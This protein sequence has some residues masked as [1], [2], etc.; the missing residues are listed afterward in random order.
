MQFHILS[1]I[2][3]RMFVRMCV[4]VCGILF[5]SVIRRL[6]GYFMQCFRLNCDSYHIEMERRRNT[7]EHTYDAFVTLNFIWELTFRIWKCF[8]CEE[9]NAFRV[10]STATFNLASHQV[11]LE[12]RAFIWF[13]CLVLRALSLSLSLFISFVIIFIVLVPIFPVVCRKTSTTITHG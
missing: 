2:V 1:R 7:R 5:R 8:C 10:N 6:F 12:F 9:D 11:I 13:F 4:C 3:V